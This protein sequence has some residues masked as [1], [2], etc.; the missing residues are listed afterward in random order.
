MLSALG[1][2]RLRSYKNCWGYVTASILLLPYLITI[3]MFLGY[4]P[5]NLQHVLFCWV[6]VRILEQSGVLYEQPI[7]NVCFYGMHPGVNN[8]YTL[9]AI[10]IYQRQQ[11]IVCCIAF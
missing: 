3:F 8:C 10:R 11:F 9:M 6:P 4:P 1:D 5:T 2:C 7:G